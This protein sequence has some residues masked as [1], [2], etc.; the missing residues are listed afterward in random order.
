[1]PKSFSGKVFS[2][3]RILDP[4]ATVCELFD[5][6]GSGWNQ[7]LLDQLFSVEERRNIKNIPISLSNQEDRLIWRGTSK[8]VFSVKN[9]YHLQKDLENSQL[10][11][12][13]SRRRDSAI[14]KYIWKLNLPNSEKVFFWRACQNI[15]PTRE[16][17]K[18]RKI[19]PDAKCLVCEREEESTAHI[20]W[21]CPS[22]KDVWGGA[23]ITFQKSQFQ[24]V[25]FLKI[26]RGNDEQMYSG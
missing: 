26:A 21:H 17:L 5:A 10:A 12:T 23:S 24:E 1:V 13:S 22:A 16:N 2:A 9:A 7:W 19:I 4:N 6:S 14:W 11:E 20:L 25:D 18:R 8:G 15:L 3:P